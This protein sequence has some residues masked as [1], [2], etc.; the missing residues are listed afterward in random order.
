ML[1]WE[2][3]SYIYLESDENPVTVDVTI[4]ANLKTFCQ[5]FLNEKLKKNTIS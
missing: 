4:S 2:N 1:K 5:N 3:G